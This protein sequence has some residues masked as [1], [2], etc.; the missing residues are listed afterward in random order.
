M[1]SKVVLYGSL[2]AY[3]LYSNDLGGYALQGVGITLVAGVL[4]LVLGQNNLLYI[5]STQG[6]KKTSMMPQ[7]YVCLG[8]QSIICQCLSYILQS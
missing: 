3:L 7:G 6:M 5:P 1:N 2:G 8:E 4:G